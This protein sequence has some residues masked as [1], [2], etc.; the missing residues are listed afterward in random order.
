MTGNKRQSDNRQKGFDLQTKGAF[1][2]LLFYY[3]IKRSRSHLNS[4]LKA[5]L[6]TQTNGVR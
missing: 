4:E 3:L 6:L 2:P 1:A 5:I